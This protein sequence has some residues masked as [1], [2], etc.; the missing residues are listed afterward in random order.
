MCFLIFLS[1]SGSVFEGL[2]GD[3]L[4]VRQN[5]PKNKPR[6]PCE[7]ASLDEFVPLIREHDSSGAGI[8]HDGEG[9]SK[10]A[11]LVLEFIIIAI[12]GAS[13]S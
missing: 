12:A 1:G 8:G 4:G 11:L 9:D 6:K 5:Y 7:G 3:G 13:Y 2:W 10:A